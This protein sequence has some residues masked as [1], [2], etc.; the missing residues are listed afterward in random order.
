MRAISRAALLVAGLHLGVLAAPSVA[1]AQGP[2]PVPYQ[3]APQP[4]PYG[5]PAP[6]PAPPPP[7]P[8]GEAPPG[9]DVIV[10]KNG[11]MLRGTII[12]AV[13]DVQARIQLATGE[14][15]TV[16]WQAIARIDHGANARRLPPTPP[17]GPMEVPGP[18]LRPM[19]WVHVEGSEDGEVQQRRG[20]RGEWTTVCSGPCDM[21]LPMGND[22]RIAGGSIRPSGVFHLSGA[23]GD[24]V[25]I[26]VNPG[27][28]A[29]FVL[30]I[31]G[32]SLGGA[33]ALV[34]L[35]VGLIGSVG[36]TVSPTGSTDRQNWQGVENAGWVTFGVGAVA[37]VG[38][39]LLITGNARTSAAPEAGPP[40]QAALLAQGDAWKKVPT[41]REATPEQKAL[42]PVMGVPLWSGRF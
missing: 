37:V 11:G 38:G 4:V 24:R 25:T 30:G 39:I 10:M 32:T 35:F 19:V 12:D 7:L 2:Q 8:Q 41:W 23:P 20:P 3:P 31:V 40:Q 34:G 15:A 29:W 6:P 16:P 33:V 42:P 21:A 9:Q 13:P 36:V 17:P 27:S 18:D 5:A 22:Y 28:K 1:W 14:V 26:N